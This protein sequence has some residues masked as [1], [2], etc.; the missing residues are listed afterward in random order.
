MYYDADAL[1]LSTHTFVAT[2]DATTAIKDIV[3]VFMSACNSLL[4][5]T[6]VGQGIGTF[7]AALN[8]NLLKLN[9]S[10]SNFVKID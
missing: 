1:N 6:A 7:F 10:I 2:I 8:T 5:V 4:T 9:A 3:V